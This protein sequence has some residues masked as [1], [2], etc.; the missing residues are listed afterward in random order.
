MKWR[1]FNILSYANSLFSHSYKWTAEK[2]SKQKRKWVWV[3]EWV[4]E[5]ASE[6]LIMF[7]FTFLHILHLS[8]CWPKKEIAQISWDLLDIFVFLDHNNWGLMAWSKVR[9]RGIYKRKLRANKLRA[10]VSQHQ[11]YWHLGSGNSLLELSIL[12]SQDL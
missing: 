10:S 1:L 3:Y 7:A 8:N 9:E 5:I 6:K 4:Y 2:K 11:H 12:A